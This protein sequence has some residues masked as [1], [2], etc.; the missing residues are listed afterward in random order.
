MKTAFEPYLV[1]AETFVFCTAISVLF[2]FTGKYEKITTNIKDEVHQKI[3]V[4]MSYTDYETEEYKIISGSSVLSEVTAYD[5]TF[6]V[7]VNSTVINN[8]PTRTGEPYYQYIQE[9]GH[10]MEEILNIV[11]ITGQYEKICYLDNHGNLKEVQ[12]ILV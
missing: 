6:G 5:G 10:D 12:Y 9:Y 4:T 1:G 11:S 3:D 8:I 7:K 2:S